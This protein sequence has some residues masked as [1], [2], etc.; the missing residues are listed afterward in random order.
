M[1]Q[2][3]I[4]PFLPLGLSIAGSLPVYAVPQTKSRRFLLK[5]SDGCPTAV[6]A[7][8][9]SLPWSHLPPSF[10]YSAEEQDF[11]G[12][13]LPVRLSLPPPCEEIP[14]VWTG[15]SSC[16][17]F[18]SCK[19]CRILQACFSAQEAGEI[20]NHTYSWRLCVWFSQL[21]I[22]KFLP[23]NPCS[24]KCVHKGAVLAN[25]GACWKCPVSNS[26]PD[27]PQQSTWCFWW[28]VS[29]W[30]SRTSTLN[31]QGWPCLDDGADRTPTPAAFKETALPPHHWLG[32]ALWQVK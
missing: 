12:C 6:P 2:S 9:G 32:T 29:T 14:E 7:A 11:P 1:A 15:P 24:S 23:S 19:F 13:M 27:L 5:K 8:G 25:L 4:P 16:K 22:K 3:E 30:S 21:V 10:L 28:F 31:N 26:S 20:C 18:N 17:F